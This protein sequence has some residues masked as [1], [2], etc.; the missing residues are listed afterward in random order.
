MVQ[1]Q[2][3]LYYDGACGL[4]RRSAAILRRLDWF[5]RLRFEDMSQTPPES[6]PVAWRTAMTGIPMRTRAGAAIVGYDALRR[7][8]LQTPI[9][10]VAGALM[11]LPGVST[12]GRRVYRRIALRRSRSLA[13]PIHSESANVDE[14]RAR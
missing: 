5:G 4:C 10:F 13:C 8:L 6:L 3:T 2:D 14:T 11:Y 1:R 9:G 7:A 12:I